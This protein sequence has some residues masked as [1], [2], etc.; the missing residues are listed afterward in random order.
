M[1]AYKV[2]LLAFL[3]LAAGESWPY[4]SKRC[5]EKLFL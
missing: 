1:A 3:A 2:A 5:G 4:E